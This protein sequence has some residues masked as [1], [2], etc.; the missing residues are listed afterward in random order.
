MAMLSHGALAGLPSP[1]APVARP[2]PGGHG[3][4][5]PSPGCGH[6]RSRGS[7]RPAHP[8]EGSGATRGL[9]AG[10]ARSQGG[11]RQAGGGVVGSG[12]TLAAEVEGSG[13]TLAAAVELRVCSP[14]AAGRGAEGLGQVSCEASPRPRGARPSASPALGAPHSQPG[15]PQHPSPTW[16]HPRPRPLGAPAPAAPEPAGKSV[17]APGCQGDVSLSEG[18][19]LR[20]D[21]AGRRAEREGNSRRP[22]S[23]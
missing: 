12:G 9:A 19:R 11:G 13:G 3:H 7:S 22:R 14:G 4:R 23:P 6:G 2:G 21:V 16:P 20:V 15:R 18:G 8:Q 5:C 10:R 17:P 1:S